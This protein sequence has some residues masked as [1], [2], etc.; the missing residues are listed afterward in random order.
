MSLNTP[1]RLAA[2]LLLCASSTAMA[3]PVILG[4]DDLTDHGS[5]SSAGLNLQGWIYFEKAV[6]NVLGG[7]TRAGAITTDIVALGSAS[8][9]GV[10]TG[11]DAGAA[12]GSAALNLGRTVT[13]IDGAAAINLFF[14]NLAAGTINPRMLW[15]AGNGATN[16][17]DSAEGA[18]LTANAAAINTFVA[19]G[20]GLMSIRNKESELAVLPSKQWKHK[21]RTAKDLFMF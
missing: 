5:R 6:N 9:L 10:F 14:T 16:D 12:I 15:I 2:A 8:T 1:K 11:S 17:I 3:G 7:K 18:A 20:G 19:S 13:Y 4:G 21:S